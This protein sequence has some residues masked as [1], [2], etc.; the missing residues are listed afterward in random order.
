MAQ[1]VISCL[2][3][4]PIIGIVYGK[5]NREKIGMP[6]GGYF[7]V[8]NVVLVRIF[9][10][11]NGYMFIVPRV[12]LRFNGFEGAYFYG[13]YKNASMMF[14]SWFVLV[15][16]TDVIGLWE[17]FCFLDGLVDD[18][19]AQVGVVCTNSQYEFIIGDL[20]MLRCFCKTV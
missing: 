10:N 8:R 5:A 9:I 12:I 11:P 3:K 7:D 1:T 4:R 15:G 20:E 16:V 17:F 13:F 2:A 18:P 19:V 6:F 14:D